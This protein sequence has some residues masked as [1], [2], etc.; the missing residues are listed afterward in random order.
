MS[1]YDKM[2]NEVPRHMLE[3][4]LQNWKECYTDNA[5][6]QEATR[7]DILASVAG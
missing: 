3:I 6:A 7:S 4:V 2:G 5:Q 1:I